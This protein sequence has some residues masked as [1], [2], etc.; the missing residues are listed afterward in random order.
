MI[1]NYCVNICMNNSN[2]YFLIFIIKLLFYLI[3]LFQYINIHNCVLN[4]YQILMVRD[5][6]MLIYNLIQGKTKA[7][8]AKDKAKASDKNKFKD[9]M[10]KALTG[11]D[12][13]KRKKWSKSKTK[14]K[15][16]NS[17]FFTKPLLDRFMKEINAQPYVT[18]TML[19]EKLSVNV[20]CIR[21]A[22]NALKE[23]N[24]IRPYSEAHSKYCC[25]VKTENWVAPTV[26][27]KDT[28]AKTKKK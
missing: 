12:K 24:Q 27:K 4:L 6:L 9:K 3:I 17:V 25:W 23:E 1:F 8:S 28:K 19:S 16:N 26:D 2:L 14:E 5:I 11:G 7:E 18:K 21:D 13:V 15:V 10:P 22:L 20:S